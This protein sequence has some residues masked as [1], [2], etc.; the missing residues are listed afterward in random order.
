VSGEREHDPATI[1]GRGTITDVAGIR[2]GHW[3]GEGTGVTVV[4]CPPETVGS[5]EVRGGAPATRELTLLEPGRTVEHVDAVVLTGGSAFGL[6]AADGVLAFLAEQGRGYPTRGGPVPIVPTAAIYDLVT[7]ESRRPGATE[8]RAAVA[9]ALESGSDPRATQ[10]GRL[11]AGR[12]ATV[13]KWRGPEHAVPGGLGNA[14]IE[15]DGATVGALAVVNAIGDVVADDGRMLAGSTAPAG[16]TSFPD[17]EPFLA[18]ATPL[19]GA[20]PRADPKPLQHTTLVVLATDARC[21]KAECH[22]LAQSGHHG[23]ARAIRPSHTRHDGDV[24]IAVATGQVDAHLDR[25]RVAAA[26]VVA[27]AVRDAVRDGRA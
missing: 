4:V 10:S 1:G 24:V 13:G 21:T 19:P 20:K 25:L 9:E 6:A 27:A 5:A 3:T 8:G 17:P 26:D 12:G 7:A 2:V 23:L 15:D 11:G 18:D 16:T 14:S 22:L